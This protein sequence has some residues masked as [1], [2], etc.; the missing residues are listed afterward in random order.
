SE[1]TAEQL[2]RTAQTLG[3]IP[4]ALSNQPPE[5]GV[6]LPPG[7]S[8]GATEPADP[9]A[10]QNTSRQATRNYEIDRTLAYTRQ[11]GGGLRRITV[12]VLVITCGS[13]T[14]MAVSAMSHIRKR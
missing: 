10:P 2:S 9:S 14:A 5:P 11:P 12:A 7:V 1:S 4:G 6:A 8:A 13:A 3:G